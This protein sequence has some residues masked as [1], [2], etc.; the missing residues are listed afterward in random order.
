MECTCCSKANKAVVATAN[1]APHFDVGRRKM[2]Y[3]QQFS[4]VVQ[5]INEG[6]RSFNE[7]LSDGNKLPLIDIQ[8][9]S[10]YSE[11]IKEEWG[12]HSWPN[13][14]SYGVYFLFGRSQREPSKLG[15]YI[16]KASMK[17]MGHRLWAHFKK[18][19]ETKDYHKMVGDEKFM[20]EAIAS[21]PMPSDSHKSISTALEEFLIV[22]GLKEATLINKVGRRQ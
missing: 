11:G 8:N 5:E 2:K 10:S 4:K 6:V 7:F 18:D 14:D 12:G 17:V 1:A 21:I 13:K 3:S 19:R 22:N 20:I 16:G 15:L 9:Q